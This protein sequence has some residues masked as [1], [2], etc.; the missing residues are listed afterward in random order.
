MRAPSRQRTS[1]FTFALICMGLVGV[2]VTGKNIVAQTLVQSALDDS[3]R[4][5]VFS[6]Y[7]VIFT[8]AP[9]LGALMIGY[10]ADR[11]GLGLPVVSAAVIGLA[12]SAA[13]LAYRKHLSP[14][15]EIPAPE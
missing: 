2:G 3:V 4:G 10:A 9:A 13:I 5:R 1:S 8:S 14:H 15:L 11:V 7:T 12:A 6:L